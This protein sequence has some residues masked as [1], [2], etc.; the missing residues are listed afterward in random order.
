M[1]AAAGFL[2]K[3]ADTPARQAHLAA[4][5]PYRVISQRLTVEGKD[6]VG[7]IYADPQVCRC[8]FVGDPTAYQRFQQMAF[9][10]HLAREQFAAAEMAGEE[11]GWDDWG[12]YPSWGGGGIVVFHGGGGFYG[13]GGFHG[14]GGGHR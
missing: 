14:G 10:E 7:Y 12:P 1:L 4:L 5:P 3:P 8:V 6:T 9:Q 11:V 13:G 2:E